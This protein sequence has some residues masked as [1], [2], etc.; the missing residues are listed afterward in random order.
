M[1]GQILL[2]T[3][4][5]GLCL[6]CAPAHHEAAADGPA[7]SAQGPE[8][9][10]AYY[11]HGT[12]RCVICLEIERIAHDT[13][14]DRFMDELAAGTLQWQSI[15]YDVDEHRHYQDDYQLSMPSLVLVRLQG[16]V[17]HDWTVLEDTWTYISEGEA[18]LAQYVAG[19]V[20]AFMEPNLKS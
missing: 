9:V 13:L 19:T 5:L 6:S 3:L 11:F 8:R 14:E 10:V 17:E 1:W 16:D 20:R 2:F 18:A 4:I 12:I 15:D 7:T